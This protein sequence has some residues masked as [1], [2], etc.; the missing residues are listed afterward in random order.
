[1]AAEKALFHTSDPHEHRWPAATRATRVA[2]PMVSRAR[3]AR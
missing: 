2:R 1:M 3:G